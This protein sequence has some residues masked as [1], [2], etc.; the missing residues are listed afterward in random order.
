MYAGLKH[1]EPRRGEENVH[2]GVQLVEMLPLLLQ[3]IL[4]GPQP[5]D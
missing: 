5:R 4:E 3:F 2:V 1:L